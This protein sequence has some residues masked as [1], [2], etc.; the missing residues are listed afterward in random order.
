V[1]RFRLAAP[2]RAAIVAHRVR[3]GYVDTDKASVAHHTV[4]LVWMEAARVEYLRQR[5]L[6]YRR[7]EVESGMGM[8]VIEA[9]LVY[10][11]PARFDDELEIETWVA[12]CT[13]AKIVFEA[14]IRRVADSAVLC[15]G[16]VTVACVDFAQLRACSVPDVVRRACS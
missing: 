9:R 14:R 15:E 8:P 13:R 6:D 5:G 7:F 11:S 12:D 1:R 16:I 3:V 4:Y 2:E 10:A